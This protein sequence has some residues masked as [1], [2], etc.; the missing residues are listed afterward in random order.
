MIKNIKILAFFI[1]SMLPLN[2]LCMNDEARLKKEIAEFTARAQSAR[3]GS[4]AQK[5]FL[6]IVESKKAELASLTGGGR[7][8]EEEIEKEQ[9][10]PARGEER[11]RQI[12]ALV[13]DVARLLREIKNSLQGTEN[14]GLLDDL[15]GALR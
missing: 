5:G 11:G 1:L 7:E 8:E 15:R 6:K 9:I 2:L 12:D 4:N 14:E 13:D 3:P 10:E